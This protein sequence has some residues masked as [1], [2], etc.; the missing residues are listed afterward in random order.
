V[1]FGAKL[2]CSN[3]FLAGRDAD[4]VIEHDLRGLCVPDIS[5]ILLP[6]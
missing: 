5:P 1:A 2:V 6:Y 4:D 3:V